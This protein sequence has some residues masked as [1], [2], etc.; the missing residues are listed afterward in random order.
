MI[1]VDV[2]SLY[3]NIFH[4]EGIE[5]VKNFLEQHRPGG[6]FPSN[7][8]LVELL[9][10]ILE[11]NNFQFDDQNYLQVGG[12]AMGTRVA[13]SLANIFMGDFEAKHIDNY[14]LKPQLVCRFIDDLFILWPHGEE[15]LAAWKE[16][17]N[18]CHPNIKFTFETS[19]ESVNFLDTT[20]H[21]DVDGNIWTDLYV[22]PTDSH[23]YLHYDSAHPQHC[24]CSLPYSQFLRVRRICSRLEDF[25]RHCIELKYHFLRRGY[26]CA[27]LDEAYKKALDTPLEVAR[28]VRFDEAEMDSIYLVE[29]YHPGDRTLQNIVETNWEVLH[30]ATVTKH[31]AESKR[32]FGNRRPKNLHD[33]LVSAKI[34]RSTCREKSNKETPC[35][36]SINK[37]S[38]RN[39]QYCP[40]IDHSGYITSYATKKQY[41]CKTNITCKSTNL[42]YCISCTRCGKQYVGQT[43][44]TLMDRFKGHF[45]MIRRRDMSKDIG[46][47]FNSDDHQGKG[48]VSIS[49]LDFIYA[50][51]D[52]PFTR[53]I[54]L[55]VEFDW[56]QE[57]KTMLPFGMNSWDKAPGPKYSR[58]IKACTAKYRRKEL[59]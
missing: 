22:K 42:I 4:D 9:G 33:L 49:V 35:C 17:L 57:L 21:L 58:N 24:K 27:D 43:G 5:S 11:L 2:N 30:R 26:K 1:A 16:H 50:P 29:T 38:T 28:Q 25:K 39:C 44:G 12:T 54:R 15:E 51:S 14:R 6:Q 37:C 46:K 13:P 53:D 45:A 32:V 55:Q 3:T 23:N 18:S 41:E 36:K 8:S 52:A 56:M 47:H 7:E 20:V 48:D 10:H 59:K 19:R 34:R 31:L 40:K